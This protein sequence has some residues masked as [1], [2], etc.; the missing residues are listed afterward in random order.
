[1]TLNRRT[2]GFVGYGLWGLLGGYR[3]VQN[4]NK[5]YNQDYKY[6]LKNP[7]YKKPQY[8]YITCFAYSFFSIGVYVFPVYAPIFIIYELYNIEK[9]IRGIEDDEENNIC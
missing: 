3:G 5:R 9:F 1:M 7:N 8:Y 6:H 2:I 4:Y